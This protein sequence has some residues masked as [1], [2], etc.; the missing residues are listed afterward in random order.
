MSLSSQFK[1]YNLKDAHATIWSAIEMER[2][3]EEKGLA[4]IFE[5]ITMPL[6]KVIVGMNSRGLM[7]DEEA[8]QEAI[9]ATESQ[10]RELS[11]NLFEMTGEESLGGKTGLFSADGDAFRIFIYDILRLKPPA[12]SGR[13]KKGLGK[14]GKEILKKLGTAYPNLSLFFNSVLELKGLQKRK[15]TFLKG[16]VPWIDGRVKPSYRIGPVTGR[17]GCKKPNFQNIPVGPGRDM[18]VAPPGKVLIYGDYSQVEIRILGL[19]ANDQL[20]LDDFKA[21]K[22]FH[23]T[24]ARMMFEI[25]PEGTVSYKQRYFAKTFFFGHIS[26]GGSIEGVKG[27]G[28]E[29]LSDIPTE[30]MVKMGERFFAGHPAIQAYRTDTEVQMAKSRTLVN[31]FGRPRI[32]FG[33]LKEVIRA[34]YN[35]RIQGGAADLKNTT[36]ILL[37][38]MFSNTLVLEVHDSIMLEVDEDKGEDV[39]RE[40]KACMERPMREFGGYSFPAEVG[41]YRSWGEA[42]KE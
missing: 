20:I 21:G 13:T 34:G 8:R 38:K 1:L 16:M 41:I 37:D 25:P 23:D 7:V 39:L 28:S 9:K 42:T 14:T 26:Y 24:N 33:P 18:F 3:I 12:K 11:N 6:M 27:R 30:R 5:T 19:I 2:E 32:F 15:S 40:M 36:L 22:D 29:L 17:L 10:I 4:P 35:Y 31:A